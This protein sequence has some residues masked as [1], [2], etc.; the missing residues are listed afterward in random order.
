MATLAETGLSGNI[1]VSR[2][3]MTGQMDV[4]LVI[5]GCRDDIRRPRAPQAYVFDFEAD[6]SA[7]PG[8]GQLLLDKP[9]GRT[10]PFR[11][12]F[13]L[14]LDPYFSEPYPNY[15]L[16]VDIDRSVIST[17][18]TAAHVATRNGLMSIVGDRGPSPHNMYVC[19]GRKASTEFLTSSL[20]VL[21]IAIQKEQAQNTDPEN[22]L[23]GDDFIALRLVHA[24]V[25]AG[26]DI[27]R[28]LPQAHVQRAVESFVVS[29]YAHNY[30]TLSSLDGLGNSGRWHMGAKRFAIGYGISAEEI[31][32]TALVFNERIIQII[33]D[34]AARIKRPQQAVEK[35]DPLVAH[36]MAVYL[37]EG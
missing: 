4:A 28:H 3:E 37:V 7:R 35:L 23:E 24:A 15:P 27:R 9:I 21:D 34:Q 18:P 33:A 36:R 30:R 5:A 25:I 22:L 2:C 17:D 13:S 31:A 10:M 14:L 16:V 19:L 1:G 20:A 8:G 26:I 29:T 12:P 6:N 11:Q 32:D